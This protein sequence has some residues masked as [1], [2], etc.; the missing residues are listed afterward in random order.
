MDKFESNFLEKF[1]MAA[2]TRWVNKNKERLLTGVGVIAT[3]YGGLVLWK[4]YLVG[5]RYRIITDSIPSED[6]VEAKRKKVF[7]VTGANSGMCD[8]KITHSEHLF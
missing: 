4:D 1:K 3:I 6:L 8:K 2:V 7:L 5:K